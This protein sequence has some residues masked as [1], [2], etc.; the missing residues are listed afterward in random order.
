MFVGRA[1]LY[2]APSHPHP[3]DLSFLLPTPYRKFACAIQ[4]CLEL[5]QYQEKPVRVMGGM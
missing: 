3:F 4:Q 5:N 2:L 1:A